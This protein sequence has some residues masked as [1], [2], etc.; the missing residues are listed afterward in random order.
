MTTHNAPIG[1]VACV[2]LRF[3]TALERE[4]IDAIAPGLELLFKSDN[5]PSHRIGLY[6]ASSDAGAATSLRFWAEAQRTGLGLA[7]PELFPWCLAN[8]PAAAL[9]RRFGI[10]GPNVSLLGEADA[11]LAAFDAAIEALVA[12]RLD[13]AVVLALSMAGRCSGLRLVRAT[14]A[15]PWRI[16]DGPPD[17]DRATLLELAEG[18]AQLSAAK[19]DELLIGD[20]GRSIRISR[21]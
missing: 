20:G 13:V 14:A 7:N 11:L 12:E 1:G 9:A 18:L 19:D 3:D 16:A 6:L 5:V 2:S 21:R 10:T 8:A 17:A 15:T 4:T